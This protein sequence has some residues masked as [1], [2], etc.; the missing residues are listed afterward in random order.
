MGGP[1]LVDLI[2]ALKKKVSE[3][4]VSRERSLAI[5]KLEEAELW[6]D[7]AVG[8]VTLLSEENV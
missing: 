3:L 6:I 8:N 5:T 7:V 1:S 2:V 4:P